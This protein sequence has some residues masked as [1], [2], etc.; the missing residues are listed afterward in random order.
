[1]REMGSNGRGEERGGRYKDAIDGWQRKVVAK[2]G[3]GDEGEI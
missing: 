2:A 3:G 1:M